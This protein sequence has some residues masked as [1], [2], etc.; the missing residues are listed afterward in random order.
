MTSVF[1]HKCVVVTVLEGAE[2]AV[3][4]PLMSHLAISVTMKLLKHR[5]LPG[6]TLTDLRG[7]EAGKEFH[8]ARD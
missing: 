3:V 6:V 7:Q 8:F 1:C 4:Y 5:M 2:K